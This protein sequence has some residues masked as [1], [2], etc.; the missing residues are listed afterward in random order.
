MNIENDENR[1]RMA[2]LIH[3]LLLFYAKVEALKTLDRKTG[4]AVGWVNGDGDLTDA[5]LRLTAALEVRGSAA[6]LLH[7]L[8]GKEIDDRVIDGLAKGETSY[9]MLSLL[10]LSREEEELLRGEEF[11]DNDWFDFSL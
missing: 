1:L 3:T 6:F 4:S 5:L 8:T 2:A 9:E 11:A 7:V 10:N